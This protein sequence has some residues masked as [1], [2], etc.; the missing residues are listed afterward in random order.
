MVVPRCCG[1]GFLSTSGIVLVLWLVFVDKVVWKNCAVGLF[2]V[3]V[4]VFGVCFGP[5]RALGSGVF[6]RSEMLISFRN[7]PFL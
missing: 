4:V 2:W 6:L 5:R 3:I 7:P 1:L